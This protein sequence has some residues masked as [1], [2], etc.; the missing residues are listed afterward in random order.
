[1]IQFV[2]DLADQA[3]VLPLILMIA[4]TLTVQGWPR[5]GLAWIGA[6]IA[7]FGTMLALKLVFMGCGETIGIETISSPS[8]H[9]AS[10]ALICGGLVA[11]FT[12]STPFAV[13]AAIA[14]SSVIGY[15]RIVLG[16]HTIEETVLGAMVGTGGAALLSLLAGIPPVVRVL[17]IIVV[18][19]AVM[20]GFHG[21]RLPAEPAIRQASAIVRMIAP[22]CVPALAVRTQVPGMFR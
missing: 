10:A 22:W 3:V 15:T 19:V 21:T 4:A 8:G 7:C 14:G 2:T 11:C 20:A 13:L 9:A 5:G 1:M 18:I 6:T 12:S 16:A 17:P